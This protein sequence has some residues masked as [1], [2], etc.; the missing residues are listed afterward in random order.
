MPDLK[1][2]IADDEAMARARMQRLLGDLGV[3]VVQACTDGT[4]VLEALEHLRVDAVFLDLRMPN[5]TGAEVAE[6]LGI[7]GPLVVFVTAHAHHAVQAFEQGAVDYL[8]K[9]VEAERLGLAVQ[10]LRERLPQ[11]PSPDEGR[12]PIPTARGVVLVPIEGITWCGIDGQSVV[13]HGE[14]TCYTDLRLA[15]L[16]RRLPPNFVRLH[17]R[18]LVNLQAIARLEDVT[19]G[20]YRAHLVD[21]A[22]VE[23]SRAAARRLRRGWRAQEARSLPPGLH[24]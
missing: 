5:L 24:R 21:G 4:E 12:L 20:G 11:V 15:D 8:L 10:R 6:L 17:R 23:V 3:E 16:E 1:V 19:S 9:P 7:A 14:R 13:L 22:V 2:L 18:A